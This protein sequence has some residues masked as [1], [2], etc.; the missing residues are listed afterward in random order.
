MPLARMLA[1]NRRDSLYRDDDYDEL[2]VSMQRRPGTGET[3]VNLPPAGLTAQ[4]S[5]Y[6]F[7]P[8]DKDTYVKWMQDQQRAAATERQPE[9]EPLCSKP[10]EASIP[11]KQPR[12]GIFTSPQVKEEVQCKPRDADERVVPKKPPAESKIKPKGKMYV[13]SF[14]FA[15]QTYCIGSGSQTRQNHT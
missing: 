3:S 11:Q 4:Q 1:E 14:L 2:K 6:Y 9:A 13:A 5:P 10:Q 15:F 7:I 12:L 8:V